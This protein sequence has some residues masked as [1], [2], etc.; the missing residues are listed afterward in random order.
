MRWL[1]IHVFRRLPP[2]IHKDLMRCINRV[3][4]RGC[5]AAYMGS[6]FQDNC[7][8]KL[9]SEAPAARKTL[10]ENQ[11]FQDGSHTSQRWDEAHGMTE[12][13]QRSSNPSLVMHIRSGDIFGPNNHVIRHHGQVCLPNNTSPQGVYHRL[14]L[15][16]LS[17]VAEVN[18][19]QK[20]VK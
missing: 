15:E 6:L 10:I 11:Q 12:A 2:G 8:R 18:N 20:G 7:A 4:L 17:S 13:E 16:C 19:S 3:F 1:I 9:A 5:E 14:S